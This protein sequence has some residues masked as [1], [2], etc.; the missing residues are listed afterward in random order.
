MLENARSIA[1]LW[2][3]LHSTNGE[4]ANWNFFNLFQDETISTISI[5][6]TTVSPLGH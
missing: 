2:T 1:G 5:Q 6:I 3:S 4:N